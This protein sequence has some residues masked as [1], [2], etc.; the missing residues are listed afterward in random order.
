MLQEAGGERRSKDAQRGAQRTGR[1]RP[2]DVQRTLG[3][4]QRTLRSAHWTLRGIQR[5]LGSAQVTLRTS[6]R[7]SEAA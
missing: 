6:R 1:G 5:T 7:R 4:A 3:G 2:E